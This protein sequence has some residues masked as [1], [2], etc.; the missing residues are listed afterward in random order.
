MSI[1]NQNEFYVYGCGNY[2]QI[3][4]NVFSQLL[5]QLKIIDFCAVLNQL[6][7]KNSSEF[8]L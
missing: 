2:Q 4:L 7:E 6:G 8:Y 1:T 3:L 5:P